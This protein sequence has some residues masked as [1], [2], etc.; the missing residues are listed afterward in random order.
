MRVPLSDILHL[1]K[2]AGWQRFLLAMENTD[3]ATLQLIRKGGAT[4]TDRTAIRLLRQHGILS[5]AT[6]VVGFEEETDRDHW[7]GLRQLLSYDPDQIQILYVTP[8][9]WTPYYRLAAERRVIQTDRRRWTTSTRSLRR[10]TC[11]AGACFSGSSSR[12]SSSRRARRRWGECS[13]TR[14]TACDT[15]YAGTRPWASSTTGGRSPA[16]RLAFWGAP[17]DAAEEAMVTLALCSAD[18][19]AARTDDG[20]R[21]NMEPF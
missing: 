9:R 10:G 8:H 15:R 12:S 19:E 1:Y 5:I 7:R 6:L 3:E 21:E 17:Q 20:F 16:R 4:S 18:L 14:I 11:R 13:F 2:Q